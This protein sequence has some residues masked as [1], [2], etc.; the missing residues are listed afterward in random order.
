[1]TI[2]TQQY[3]FSH[4][5]YSRKVY[6]F[7]SFPFALATVGDALYENKPIEYYLQELDVYLERIKITNAKT[8][9][10]AEEFASLLYNRFSKAHNLIFL[11]GYFVGDTPFVYEFSITKGKLNI[12]RLNERDEKIIYGCYWNGFKIPIDKLLLKSPQPNIDFSAM[13]V[14]D[15]IEFTEFLIRTTINYVRFSAMPKIVG[16]FVET[17]IVTPFSTRWVSDMNGQRY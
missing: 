14:K 13:N 5:V 15:A 4:S 2:Q 3:T 1:M 7:R 12:K 10:S 9:I 11:L 17:I 8:S 6:L 16:G